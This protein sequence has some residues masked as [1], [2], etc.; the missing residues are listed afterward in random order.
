[1][2][3]SQ[4]ISDLRLIHA[5]QLTHGFQCAPT[6]QS[7]GNHHNMQQSRNE[8]AHRSA[9]LQ[10]PASVHC[11]LTGWKAIAHLRQVLLC[12][13]WHC[14]LHAPQSLQ[15]CLR[16]HT[17]SRLFHRNCTRIITA[18]SA[19]GP[20]LN[21]YV[22]SMCSSTALQVNVLHINCGSYAVACSRTGLLHLLILRGAMDTIDSSHLRA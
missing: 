20:L 8:S 22:M 1:M 3:P 9:V 12:S 7:R 11:S 19:F 14:E 4:G 17:I 5:A 10:S 18:A 6:L 15:H 2:R 16:M 21:I 13:G